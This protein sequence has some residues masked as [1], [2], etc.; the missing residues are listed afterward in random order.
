MPQGQPHTGALAS[1]DWQLESP[2]ITE[3]RHWLGTSCLSRRS[4]GL[5][6]CQSRGVVCYSWQGSPLPGPLWGWTI[7]WASRVHSDS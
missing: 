5:I 3:E 1:W 2:M 6:S 4:D 7:P